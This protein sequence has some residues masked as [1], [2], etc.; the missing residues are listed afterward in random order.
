MIIS[1]SPIKP[2]DPVSTLG[3]NRID[4]SGIE[5]VTDV[6]VGRVIVYAP[7]ACTESGRL[8]RTIRFRFLVL[9]YPIEE[10][11]EGK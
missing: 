4:M 5:P 2:G 9:E 7:L 11:I 1:L 3:A 8:S 6:V 10:Y